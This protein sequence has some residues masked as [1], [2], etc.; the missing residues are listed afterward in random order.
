MVLSLAQLT[1][2]IDDLFDAIRGKLPIK[3]INPVVCKT[4]REM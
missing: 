2:Q 4:Y 3:L 1:Q